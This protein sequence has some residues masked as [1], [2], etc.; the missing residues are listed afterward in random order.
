MAELTTAHN[1]VARKLGARNQELEA[2]VATLETMVQ[3]M[4]TALG[5]TQGTEATFAK[6]A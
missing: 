2:R 6:A 1:A 4:A 5:V 3:K